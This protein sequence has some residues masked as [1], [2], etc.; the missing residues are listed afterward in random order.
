MIPTVTALRLLR[1]T[2]RSSRVPRVP[3]GLKAWSDDPT[4]SLAVLLALPVSW[5]VSGFGDLVT[6]ARQLPAPRNLPIDSLVVLLPEGDI[7]GG[8]V[9][10]VLRA[11]HAYAAR[12][13]RCSAL[14][15]RGYQR[16]G[17]GVEVESE[18]DLAWG[19]A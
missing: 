18:L 15:A 6:V 4:A 13:V 19:Y 10:R 11:R 9:T 2:Q 1:S 8:F 5:P 17:G 3:F 14:L 16:V 12:A 7:A